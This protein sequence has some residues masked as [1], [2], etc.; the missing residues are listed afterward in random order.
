MTTGPMTSL[1]R[2]ASQRVGNSAVGGAARQIVT[3]DGSKVT[4]TGAAIAGW[5]AGVVADQALR[6]MTDQAVRNL[7]P[8]EMI[9]ALTIEE[10]QSLFMQMLGAREAFPEIPNTPEEIEAIGTLM[11]QAFRAER[12]Q[13]IRNEQAL[14][15]IESLESGSSDDFEFAEMVD[16]AFQAK[17]MVDDADLAEM[18][19]PTEPNNRSNNFFNDV[20]S[21]LG[22]VSQALF[23]SPRRSSDG[24]RT[25]MEIHEYRFCMSPLV[26][27]GGP[28]RGQ[29]TSGIVFGDFSYVQVAINVI[30]GSLST[31]QGEPRNAIVITEQGLDSLTNGRIGSFSDL[32]SSARNFSYG[33]W[34][35]S[36]CLRNMISGL[37]R[38]LRLTRSANVKEIVRLTTS[39][40]Q[41]EFLATLV[42]N[43]GVENFALAAIE[44]IRVQTDQ[45]A[46]TSAL[47]KDVLRQLV[48]PFGEVVQLIDREGN[49]I[50]DTANVVTG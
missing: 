6:T 49:A 9:S 20:A 7:D 1:I 35:D 43:I 45:R 29:S 15:V 40:T 25:S 32:E 39:Q 36:P 16:E 4:G 50:T 24:A 13:M 33:N 12:Q 41:P 3:V 38:L 14:R 48:S 21:T 5:G 44:Y 47:E 22:S 30:L 34:V 28:S 8:L 2:A 46:Q 18:P 37:K 42:E 17:T 11:E 23:G 31:G 19:A 10:D 26:S 27:F